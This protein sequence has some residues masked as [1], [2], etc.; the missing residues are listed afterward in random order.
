MKK[1]LVAE[2]DFEIRKDIVTMFRNYPEIKIYEAG[3]AEEALYQYFKNQPDVLIIDILMPYGNAPELFQGEIDPDIT[4]TGF[5]LIHYIRINEQLNFSGNHASWIAVTTARNSP[6]I[7]HEIRGLLN[8]CGNIYLKPFNTF[9]LEN[10]IINYLGLE[11]R[12]NPIL[13]S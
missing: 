9:L 6:K 11:S 10:D 1:I 3:N 4:E 2:D 8:D 5:R 12:I 13:L 7:I